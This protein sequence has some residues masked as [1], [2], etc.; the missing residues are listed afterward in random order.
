MGRI[1]AVFSSVQSCFAQRLNV[2]EADTRKP[3]TSS[4]LTVAS[5]P[6]RRAAAGAHNLPSPTTPATRRGG[7]GFNGLD[8]PAM[9][10]PDADCLRYPIPC[11]VQTTGWQHI[12]GIFTSLL[13][14]LFHQKPMV[15]F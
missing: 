1:A 10:P 6:C 9:S 8:F 5:C 4:T 2:V 15:T 7:H 11:S 12:N 3:R 13:I 14:L